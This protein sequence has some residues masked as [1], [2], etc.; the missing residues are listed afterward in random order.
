MLL[1]QYL[2][3]ASRSL[4]C[5]HSSLACWHLRA[6]TCFNAFLICFLWTSFHGVII[7]WN[8]FFKALANALETV[9]ALMGDEANAFVWK[10]EMH[11]ATL[12][13]TQD[14]KTEPQRRM[15]FFRFTNRFLQLTSASEQLLELLMELLLLKQFSA[16]GVLRCLWHG[17]MG[18]LYKGGYLVL[19]ISVWPHA[20]GGRRTLRP[21]TVP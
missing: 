18:P 6:G 17:G 4:T 2:G 7:P 20:R 15:H 21:Q 19:K 1:I 14:S 16:V 12:R 11:L 10:K 13:P 8:A 3:L 5:W 9:A